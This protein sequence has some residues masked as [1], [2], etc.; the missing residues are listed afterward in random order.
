[1]S[2]KILNNK[3][4]KQ[5]EREKRKSIKKSLEDTLKKMEES[6]TSEEWLKQEN[7]FVDVMANGD[8]EKALN[9]KE[10]ENY[11]KRYHNLFPP[12]NFDRLYSKN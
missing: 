1:M 12:E 7:I 2:L 8:G 4:K 6:K 9:K 5:E 3:I 10:I 11:Y